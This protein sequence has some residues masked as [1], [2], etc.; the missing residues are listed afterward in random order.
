M[1]W[2]SL[3]FSTSSE[4][5][6][7]PTVLYQLQLHLQ[8]HPKHTITDSLNYQDAPLQTDDRYV[9]SVKALSE[10]WHCMVNIPVI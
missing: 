10:K 9:Q 8:I 4:N 2:I 6:K 1:G 3:L 7:Q 5:P